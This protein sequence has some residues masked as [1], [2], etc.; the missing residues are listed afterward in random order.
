MLLSIVEPVVDEVQVA[1]LA[2]GSAGVVVTDTRLRPLQRG[3]VAGGRQFA[4]DHLAIVDRVPRWLGEGPP[5]PIGRACP[6]SPRVRLRSSKMQWRI[7]GT[8]MA[9]RSRLRQWL[10]VLGA[11]SLFVGSPTLDPTIGRIDSASAALAPAVL[12]GAGDIA[13]CGNAGASATANLVEGIAGT[14][15]TLGDNVQDN[16]TAAEFSNCYGP[17]WG[18]FRS[19]TRPAVGNHEYRRPGAGPYFDYFGAAA[20]PAGRG[21]YSYNVG[22][23]HVVVL[24][25]NCGEVGCSASSAQNTWLRNDL[26]ASSS[27]CTLA[28]MHHPR[29]SVGYFG[30]I[31]SVR[32]LWDT[33]YAAGAELVLS[34]HDHN[35]QRFRPMRPDGSRDTGRGI[36]QIVAGTGGYAHGPANRTNRN[37]VTKNITTFG[38]VRLTLNSASVSLRYLSTDGSYGDSAT[39]NCH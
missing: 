35:Y 38:V 14:V 26:A 39:I 21:Y 31:S 7:G 34:G 13:N 23:W 19:R 15:F 20:G 10:V 18:R 8:L 24:N 16:G 1:E 12:V 4:G 5:V 17:T 36:V 25:S 6:G 33:L 28:Y 9:R 11:T 27:R 37:L 22:A 3:V 2:T 30:N 29:F 32:P